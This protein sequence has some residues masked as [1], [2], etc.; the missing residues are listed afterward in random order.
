MK[1]T[2]IQSF[3]R[4]RGL[5]GFAF[6]AA[7]V[8]LYGCRKADSTVTNTPAMQSVVA[9]NTAFALDLYQQ[10]KSRPGNLF[11]APHSL[12]TTLAMMYAG[13]RGQTESEMAKALHFNL[14]Q[15]E[16]H[17]AF[18]ALAA[19]LDRV[20][21]RNRVTL[22]SAHSLWCQAG[23][24]FENEFL[25]LT[26]IRY[27]AEVRSVD[28]NNAPKAVSQIN[29]WVERKTSG[30]I[31]KPIEQLAFNPRLILCNA[32]YFKGRWATLFN[33]QDTKLS[34]FFIAPERTVTV[35]MMHQKAAFKTVRA[36]G[37]N[38]LELPYAGNDLSMIILLPEAVDG[39]HGLELELTTSYLNQWIAE[40]RQ[41]R[42]EEVL[43]TL[44]RFR[45][46][47]SFALAPELTALGMTSVFNETADFSGM[48]GA[49]NF[50]IADVIHKTWVE[51]NEEG[52]EAAAAT[53]NPA[54]SLPPAFKVDHP[55]IFL[56]RENRSGCILF[57]GRVTDPSKP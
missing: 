9:G 52:T 50:F 21:R 14:P 48:T 12:S 2:S 55:F 8:M 3:R 7:A 53:Y 4:W 37:V 28:F 46:S 29:S 22:A 40:L 41:A 38:L 18:G 27:Q 34:P 43:V 45:T 30:R 39:L 31:K 23:V 36:N 13:A 25:D 1:T 19:Q 10:L 49:T 33:P 42:P 57:F 11:F 26:R 54:P 56:I 32:V 35:P 47:Q 24:P 17:A 51:V 5:T 15:D 44:P 20:Q 16:V 6:A